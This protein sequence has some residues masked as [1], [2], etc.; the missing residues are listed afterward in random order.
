MPNAAKGNAVTDHRTDSFRTSRPLSRVCWVSGFSGTKGDNMVGIGFRKEF[1]ETLLRVRKDK[2]DFIEFAPENWMKTGG[3]YHRQLQ[4]A[5]EQYPIFCHGLSLSIGSPDEPDWDFLADLKQF[6]KDVPVVRYSDHISFSQVSNAHLYELLPL[7]MIE[8]A[9]SRI[10]VKARQVQDF[11]ER[12]LILENPSYYLVTEADM[13][14]ADFISAVLRESGCGF[15]LDVNNV[16]V[17]S[18]N[19][20]YDPAAFLR[21]LPAEQVSYLHI[22][23]HLKQ[24][25]GFLLD[26]HGEAIADP[27][28]DLLKLTLE[29]LPREVP[30]L[31]ERDFNIPAWPRL[32]EEMN[33]IR[34]IQTEVR[35]VQFAS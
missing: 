29:T 11:L 28:Y 1:S 4:K 7:P 35:E 26:T 31:L 5:A 15:L 21:S 19:H 30:I 22:A 33:R 12:P 14:E 32:R 20:G 13:T 25:D 3:Y 23:G 34:R 8:E 27:V 6:F 2:P 16:Y 24:P 9:V 18:V 17:N 10:A